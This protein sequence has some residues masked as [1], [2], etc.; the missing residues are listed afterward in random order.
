MSF[1]TT[2]NEGGV[3]IVLLYK[4][5]D[6]VINSNGFFYRDTRGVPSPIYFGN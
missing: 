3:L 2:A 1:R 4:K 5:E 6:Y